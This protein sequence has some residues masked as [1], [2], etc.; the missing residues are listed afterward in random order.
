MV[1]IVG[2]KG[3]V[4]IEIK[5]VSEVLTRLRKLGKDIKQGSDVG[6]FLAANMIQNEVQESIIGNRAEP[7]SVATGRFANSIT[8]NKLKDSEFIVFT[9]VEYAKYLEY[10]TSSLQPRSHFRNTLFRNQKK[11][12]E[13]IENE[14]KR[15]Y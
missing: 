14:I 4:Q 15:R 10:G 11:I 9:D 6:A 12:K 13:I 7:R 1:Q 2:S 5:G 3:G 8:L